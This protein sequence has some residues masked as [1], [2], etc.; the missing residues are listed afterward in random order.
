MGLL[1]QPLLLQHALKDHLQLLDVDGLGQVV[2][3]PQLHGAHR[4]LHGAVGRHD[5]DHGLGVD[6]LDLGQQ[7]QA[8]H[9]RHA[10]VGQDDVGVRLLEQGQPGAGVVGAAHLVAV[11][12]EQRL[13]RRRRVDLVVDDHDPSFGP[14]AF[15]SP[16]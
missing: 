16:F 15:T 12:P 1:E 3:G 8:V 14:H 4:R 5:D 9:A 6:L 10:Q 11:L 7:L 2:L 13:E